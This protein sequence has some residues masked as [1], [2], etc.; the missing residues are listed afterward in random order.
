MKFLFTYRRVFKQCYS[1]YLQLIDD[2]RLK[3]D[4]LLSRY[5]P[6][7]NRRTSLSFFIKI[8]QNTLNHQLSIDNRQSISGSQINW[9]L[10]FIPTGL[11]KLVIGF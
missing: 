9:D 5:A 8:G 7:Q 1:F 4:D 2:C 6:P 11:T 3:I 10:R